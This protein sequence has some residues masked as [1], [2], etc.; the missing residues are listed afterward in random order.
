[1]GTSIAYGE[2]LF[3]A[4][5]AVATLL[6]A[7]GI[8]IACN[9]ANDFFDARQGADTAERM[10]PV[11]AV[12]AGLVSARAML[13]ATIIVIIIV[14][15]PCVLYLVYRGG[16]PFALLG[17]VSVILAFAYTGS[18]WSL[19]YLGLGDVFAFLF[20]GPI[21]VAGTYAAQAIAWSW[22]PAIAG[23]GVGLLACALISV[24]N[25]RDE[26]TDRLAQK[27]TLAV[28]FGPAWARMEFIT[29]IFAA[30]LTA[31]AIAAWS[32]RWWCATAAIASCAIL[33]SM[34]RVI[35]GESGRPLNRELAA[36]GQATLGYGILFSIGW[37]L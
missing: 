16:W 33:P 8:Q 36:T 9:F 31:I 32:S 15:L 30:G 2:G 4:G 5:G 11:R 19:A 1:M 10:G 24:N 29:C 23:C 26:P 13:C 20:F 34:L 6:G 7:L 37:N 35:R 22:T 21:A 28:R 18:R 12:A 14:V 3:H 27:R 25:L 17:T